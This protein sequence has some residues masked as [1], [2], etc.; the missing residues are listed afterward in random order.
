MDIVFT[1]ESMRILLLVVNTLHLYGGVEQTILS[2][3]QICGLAKRFERFL[4]VDVDC[5]GEFAS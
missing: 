2:A 3:A 4:A 5:H 1:N